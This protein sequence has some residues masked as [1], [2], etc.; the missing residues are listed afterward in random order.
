V[1]LA[2]ALIT[3]ATLV[4]NAGVF[5][6]LLKRT[7]EERR[8]DLALS[9]S[10][11]LTAQ[12]EVEAARGEA[13]DA[14]YRRV[15]SAYQGTALDV[16]ELYVADAGMTTIAAVAG[17]APAVPDIGLRSALY[18]SQQFITILG[19]PWG[20][21]Y[22]QVTSPVAPRGRPVA[23]LR[24]SVPLKAPAVPGG[25]VGFALFYVGGS[26]GLVSLF[27]YTL[28]RRSLIQPVQSLVQGTARISG[29]DFGHQVELDAARELQGLCDALNAMSTSLSDYRTRTEEQ[30]AHLESAYQELAQAQE[31]LIRS[32]KLASVGRLAA[33][34]A[35][36]VGNPLTAVLGYVDLVG[37]GLGDPV[38]EQDLVARAR[39]ELDRI[40]RIIRDLLDFARP[41]TGRAEDVAVR[42]ALEDARATV[43]PTPSIRA[44]RVVVQAAANLPLV[45]IERDKLHQVLVNLLLNAGDALGEREGGEVELLAELVQDEAGPMVEIRCRDNGPGLDPVALD[46]A[47]EPFFTTKDV[48]EGTG[49]GLA[50]CLQVV[51]GAGGSIAV[52]NRPEGGACMRLRLPAVV[53]EDPTGSAS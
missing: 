4:L 46:R 44:V 53:P 30:L 2:L 27:G 47:F 32:E 40:N 18:A 11:A 10:A 8:T 14:G 42:P 33:G 26:F 28:F 23:A 45:H 25:V 12:L 7:E 22:V 36:E 1:A 24:V 39:T 49:L 21:R 37:Q 38:L 9:L 5:W 3:L 6:L 41:G 52:E 19:V 43:A 35:H 16:D 13:R 20:A 50:T 34:I 29:G 15:L 17:Q 31:A 51:E 48:G